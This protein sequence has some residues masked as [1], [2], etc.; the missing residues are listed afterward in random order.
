MSKNKILVLGGDIKRETYIDLLNAAKKLDVVLDLVCYD[1]LFFDTEKGSGIIWKDKKI[2]DYD[3]YFF[4]HTE[5][6][7]EDVNLI[8]NYLEKY[9]AENNLK[10]PIIIDPLVSFGRFAHDHKA[11]QMVILSQAGVSVPKTIYGSIDFLR[12][13]AVKKFDFPL[14]IKGT[15]GDRKTQV[16]VVNN[17]EEFDS[18]MDE[19]ELVEKR[20]ENKYMLQEYI[21]N[22]EDYRVMVLGDKV[23]GVM[24]RKVGNIPNV[25]NEFEKADLSVEVKNLC[26]KASQACGV[27]I[28]GVDVVFRNNDVF[29]QPL[30]YEVNKTPIYKKFGEYLEIDVAEE[31]VKFLRDVKQN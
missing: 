21:V 1:E 11:N 18:K 19:L 6:H 12:K 20:F 24:K 15:K 9:F 10:K 2:E 31:I 23:L 8:N 30:F 7:W 5:K 14:V 17:K 22:S 28:A 29:S 3:V 26:V 16:F 4:R 27:A 25:K 13:I